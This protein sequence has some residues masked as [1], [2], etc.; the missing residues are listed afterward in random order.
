MRN[1]IVAI[2]FLVFGVLIG[3]LVG[4]MNSDVCVRT[5]NYPYYPVHQ[6]DYILEVEAGDS[7]E[8]MFIYD[9]NHQPVGDYYTSSPDSLQIIIDDDNR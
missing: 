9:N 2:G 4:Y 5:V 6:Y 3:L 8:H 1:T 7:I